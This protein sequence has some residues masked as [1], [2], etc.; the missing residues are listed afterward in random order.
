[1][2]HR[3]HWQGSAK[4]LGPIFTADPEIVKAMLATQFQDFGK[5]E[6]FHRDWK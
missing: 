1:M 2:S 3:E 4:A 6:P 5:G